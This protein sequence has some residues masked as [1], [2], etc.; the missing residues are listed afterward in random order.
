MDYGLKKHF[1]VIVCVLCAVSLTGFG[2]VCLYSAL[3]GS[4]EIPVNLLQKQ[5]LLLGVAV[6]VAFAVNLLDEALLQRS[7][8]LGVLIALI[9]LT[10]VLI[11]GIGTMVNGSRR[12]ID[13]GFTRVQV[14]EIAKVFYL[15]GLAYYLNRFHKYRETFWLGFAVPMAFVGLFS[16]LIIL[17]PDFGTAFLFGIVGVTL[18]YLWG[19]KLIYLGSSAFIGLCGFAFLIYQDPVR[20]KRITSFMDVEANKLD[21]AYQLYQSLLAFGAGGIGGAGIGNG[22]QQLAYLPES[23]TDFIFSVIGEEL[24]LI[25]TLLIVFL[26]GGLFW[27]ILKIGQQSRS[28]FWYM[29][30]IGGGCFLIYQALFNIGV[31]TGLLPTKGISLPFISYGGSNLVAS[32]LMIGLI[33]LAWRQSHQKGWI[34]AREL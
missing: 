1:P 2:L 28:V 31:V 4:F 7:I 14:S 26:F 8:W 15:L 3:R 9:A 23:H 33:V 12:W 11:P 10:L 5:C 13:L 22:R 29:V 6:F 21:G 32:G 30:S 18:I 16:G 25:A 17:E 19:G 27:S 20:L 24:G 34:R